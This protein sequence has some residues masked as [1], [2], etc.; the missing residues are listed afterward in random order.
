MEAIQ[1]TRS[2][3]FLLSLAMCAILT[4]YTM[5]VW[6]KGSLRGLS[7]AIFFSAVS[8][9][10]LLAVEA[11]GVFH[12]KLE[13]T[14]EKVL[15]LEEHS[16]EIP[17]LFNDASWTRLLTLVDDLEVVRSDLN[18]LLKKRDFNS[19]ARLGRFLCG[20]S[21][22]VPDIPREDGAVELRTIAFWQR[23]VR[24]LL[25]RMV[26][27]VDDVARRQGGALAGGRGLSPKFLDTLEDVKNYLEDGEEE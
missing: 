27:K 8:R 19:A 4:T 2:P 6:I 12:T 15:S 23:E 13:R 26:S 17:E 11:A 7:K 14:I 5:F 20:V 24:D 21:A 10:E 18:V 1:F 9:E 25:Y 3:I 16:S 22:S